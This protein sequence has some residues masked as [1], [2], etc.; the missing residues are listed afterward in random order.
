MSYYT[1]KQRK[2]VREAN[3]RWNFFTGAVRSGKTFI[4]NDLL[5]K[6]LRE[7][8]EGRRAIIGKTEVTIMRNVLDPLQE[9]TA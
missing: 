8:P 6:R 3:A 2:A 4:S 9:S 7:L 1:P 5:V